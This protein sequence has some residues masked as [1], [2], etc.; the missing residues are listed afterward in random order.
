[1]PKLLTL[2]ALALLLLAEAPA[3]AQPAAGGAFAT[4]RYRNLFAEADPH[5]RDAEISAR[6][7]AYWNSLFGDDPERRVYYP[8]AP[9][10][11]GRPL[12]FTTSTMTTSAPRACPT[13]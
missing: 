2:A 12:I 1:M 4:G 6:L 7:D 3:P 11:T 10:P 13:A 9:T 5:I 8:G